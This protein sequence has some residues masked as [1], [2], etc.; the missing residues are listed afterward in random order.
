MAVNTR[1]SWRRSA[2]LIGRIESGGELHIALDQEAVEIEDL[3]FLAVSTL[4]AF[5]AHNPFSRR[6]GVR[7][8]SSE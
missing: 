4:A 2:S 1:P 8:K 7:P 3:H 6:S 5:A